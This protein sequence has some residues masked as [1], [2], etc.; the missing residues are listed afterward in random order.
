MGIAT[1]TFFGGGGGTSLCSPLTSGST[2]SSGT[3]A[4]SD[5]LGTLISPLVMRSA[6]VSGVSSDVALACIAAFGIG[7]GSVAGL[8]DERDGGLPFVGDAGGSSARAGVFSMR[9]RALS[10]RG[11]EVRCASW[12]RAIGFSLAA[13]SAGFG[14]TPAA[15]SS[16]S[17]NSDGSIA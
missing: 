13:G 15:T 7:G 3:S 10:M 17:V 8:R 16:S 9:S 1:S 11:S 14:V 5:S 2:S 6:S 4:R 12:T